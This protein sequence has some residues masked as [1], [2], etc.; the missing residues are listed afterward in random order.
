MQ[1]TGSSHLLSTTFVF[2]FIKASGVADYT[3]VLGVLYVIEVLA[4]VLIVL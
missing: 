2:S 4:A 1:F 3:V